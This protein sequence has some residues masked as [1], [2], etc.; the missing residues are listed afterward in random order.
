MVFLIVNEVEG[1]DSEMMIVECLQ[2]RC[3]VLDGGDEFSE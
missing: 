2:W 3:V 1:F